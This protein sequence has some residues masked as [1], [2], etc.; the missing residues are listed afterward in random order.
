MAEVAEAFDVESPR[1]LG[2][3]NQLLAGVA[4][5][6]GDLPTADAHWELAVDYL[7]QANQPA[8]YAVTLSN[9]A[10]HYGMTGRYDASEAAFLQALEVFREAAPDA[11]QHGNILRMY[12]GLLF[13]MGRP[14]EALAA[15][16][17]ALVILAAQ[18]EGYA[19]FVAQDNYARFSLVKG[20]TERT[21]DAIEGGLE[22]AVPAYGP[23]GDVTRRMLPTFARLLVFGGRDETAGRLLRLE[24]AVVCGDTAARADAVIA[25]AEIIADAPD[26]AASRMAIAAAIA[27]AD[28]GP[29]GVADTVAA[30][31]EHQHTFLD[32]LD[33]WRYLRDLERLAG[34]AGQSLPADLAARLAD[35][36]V[37]H[38]AT[39]RLLG[40]TRS[41]DV[42]ALVHAL[43]PGAVSTAA[44]AC[45]T[46]SATTG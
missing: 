28:P 2:R 37:R 36:E 3:I 11:V 5:R 46:L 14:D 40:E 7:R 31:R 21:L 45:E 20:D 12:A 29:G 25:A 22:V 15:L 27:G 38:A 9:M 1:T 23:D 44:T 13:R 42:N 35:V 16:D 32:V 43:R 18:E 24:E 30:Y 41:D 26:V 33:H 8:G 34:Q 10:L 39:V 6:A 4:R 19:Y 17:E